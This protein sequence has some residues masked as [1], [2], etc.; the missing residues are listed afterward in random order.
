MFSNFGFYVST[1]KDGIAAVQWCLQPDG[2]YY[3][4]EDGVGAT[5]DFEIWV[6]AFIDKS[7]NLHIPFQPMTKEQKALY[8]EQSRALPLI[9]MQIG[10]FVFC[11]ISPFLSAK[12]AI[13]ECIRTNCIKLP[14][15]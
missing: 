14:A 11:Q 9:P 10:I 13:S 15:V 4:D 1:F 5:R 2:R 3:A 8:Q 12:I 7:A 6:T